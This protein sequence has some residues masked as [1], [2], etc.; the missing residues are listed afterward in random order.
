[1]ISIMFRSMLKFV[2]KKASGTNSLQN[3]EISRP[4]NLI[5]SKHKL[6]RTDTDFILVMEDDKIIGILDKRDLELAVVPT[7]IAPSLSSISPPSSSVLPTDSQTYLAPDSIRSI[8]ER[9]PLPLSSP[10]GV[11]PSQYKTLPAGF[12]AKHQSNIPRFQWQSSQNNM[13]SYGEQGSSYRSTSVEQL[14]S[15]PILSANGRNRS[16][17]A[18]RPQGSHKYD[19]ISFSPSS[20]QFPGSSSAQCNV[21]IRLGDDRTP[22][23]PPNRA[24]PAPL[25]FTRCHNTIVHPECSFQLD[26]TEVQTVSVEDPDLKDMSLEEMRRHAED[27]ESYIQDQVKQQW[28]QQKNETEKWIEQIAGKVAKTET[29]NTIRLEMTNKKRPSL[30]QAFLPFESDTSSQSTD[31]T[32]PEPH[33][34]YEKLYTSR[35]KAVI[36][37]QGTNESEGDIEDMRF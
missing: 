24:P 25:S 35:D 6:V 15:P 16:E 5:V 14:F 19:T 12:G 22:P 10:T 11:S 37:R 9:T 20:N 26:Y 33:N 30:S 3:V 18:L 27:I 17:S 1:M 4:T 7:D 29:M 28:S 8:G 34:G 21:E 2:K 13:T 32:D 23:P 31:P 36:K